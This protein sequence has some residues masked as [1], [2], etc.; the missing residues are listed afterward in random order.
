MPFCFLVKF[1]K[2]LSI[3]VLATT[4][5]FFFY[6]NLMMYFRRCVG[7]YMIF[8]HFF[9]YEVKVQNFRFNP[10]C[11]IKFKFKS[12]V[13]TLSLPPKIGLFIFVTIAQRNVTCSNKYTVHDNHNFIFRWVKAVNHRHMASCHHRQLLLVIHKQLVVYHQQARFNHNNLVPHEL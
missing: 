4:V 1:L 3:I 2:W 11:A 10:S 8:R 6:L 12:L 9:A 13:V 5:F 7:F